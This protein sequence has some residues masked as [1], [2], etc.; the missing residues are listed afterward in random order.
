MMRNMRRM[1][2][3]SADQ[4][5]GVFYYYLASFVFLL[6]F[7]TFQRDHHQNYHLNHSQHLLNNR[8]D[9]IESGGDFDEEKKKSDKNETK[10]KTKQQKQTKW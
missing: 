6:S 3:S 1:R 10:K 4:Q 5:H 2:S 9:T 7:V 8:A